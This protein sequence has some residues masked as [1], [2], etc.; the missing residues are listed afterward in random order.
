MRELGRRGVAG[1]IALPDGLSLSVSGRNA[2]A[3]S[4]GC[5]M[6]R[7][8]VAV[9]CSV[10]FLVAPTFAQTGKREPISQNSPFAPQTE[11][12]QR[13]SSAEPLD[14]EQALYQL[15]I[16]EIAGQRGR[17]G[18]AV[19]GI[20]DLAQRTRD[21]RLARRAV[22]MGFQARDMDATLDAS[23]LWLDVQ[24]DSPLARQAL[25]AALGAHGSMPTV[26]ANLAKAL[27]TAPSDGT[28]SRVA[29]LLPHVPGLLSRFG[30]KAANAA[31]TRELAEPHAQLPEAHYAVALAELN[32]GDLAAADAAVGR[33][34]DKRRDWE[35]AVVLKSRILRAKSL[36]AAGE[37]LARY[38][39]SRPNAV[40]ARLQYARILFAQ[41]AMLSAR[42]QFRALA[43]LEPG[44]A[45]HPHAAALISQQIDDLADAKKEFHRALE[46]NPKDPHAL[47]HS[48]GQVADAQSLPDVA[49]EHYRQVGPGDYFVNAQ[50]KIAGIKSRLGGIAEGRAFL[51]AA[52]NA[53]EDQPATRVQLILAEVQLLRDAKMYAV[54]FELLASHIATQPD[55]T[56]LLY[57]RAMV[58]EKLGKLEAMETDLRRVIEL[59]PDNAHAHNALGYTFA[60]R[61]M[62]LDEAR[63]LIERAVEL[64]PDDAFI[65]DSLG[66]LQFRQGKIDESLAT[67]QRAYDKRRDPEIAAHLAEVM[68]AKGQRDEARKL[69]RAALLEHGD[70]ESLKRIVKQAGVE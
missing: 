43:K 68:L 59:K 64:Q 7:S 1:T 58:A 41:N 22:E 66:W 19:R 45:D 63:A 25:G 12:A 31:T 51:V 40:D 55:D 5:S 56:D 47:H 69:L 46:R 38:L 9:G 10:A 13:K 18:L 20:A 42:E 6:F 52:Q 17:V 54:A 14:P 21:A 37:Y 29:A 3:V 60:E 57:D 24:P 65:Q 62:R 32:A 44:V 30:D 26:K 2:M 49:L 34:L 4:K 28:S 39:Q 70:N 53:H 61:N 8:M 11:G 67:L 15:L 27:A 23:L 35:L 50:L 36:D 33:A 48:L 16:S